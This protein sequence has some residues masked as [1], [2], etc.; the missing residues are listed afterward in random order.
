MVHPVP[1]APAVAGS[2]FCQSVYFLLVR[3][4]VEWSARWYAELEG[5]RMTREQNYGAAYE[6][7]RF[8]YD[9]SPGR[10]WQRLNW[11]LY[12]TLQAA[13]QA[14]LSFLPD[15]FAAIHRSMNGGYWMGNSEGS[16]CGES[17]YS[18]AVRQGHIP[19]CISF[20]K[21][22]NRPAFIWAEE[23]KTPGRLCIGSKFTW[24][25]MGIEVTNIKKDTL[26]ACWYKYDHEG[27]EEGVK[28]GTLT[29]FNGGYRVIQEIDRD[30]EGLEVVRFG[31]IVED[32]GRKPE[33]IFKI[34]ADQLAAKRKE[35]DK[36]R[37]TA[38]A[39]IAAARNKIELEPIIAR[40]TA[41]G[42]SAFRR[43]DLEEIRT[44][45]RGQQES[46]VKA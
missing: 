1:L 24:E 43:F 6:A 14:R 11:S 35:Y 3:D 41:M 38:L 40:Y 4:H 44:A 9:H 5:E 23:V 39:E 45:I 27:T 15:D 29:H 42:A 37:K 13:I 20:E 32:P 8:I 30:S 28:K 36:T 17:L 2:D 16:E 19:A 18:F 26:I 33:R 21:W 7:V 31:P 34:T 25:G 12:Q 46:F 10:S 22:K